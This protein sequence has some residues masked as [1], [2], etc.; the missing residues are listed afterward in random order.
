MSLRPHVPPHPTHDI[1]DHAMVNTVREPLVVLDD[2]LC[3]C[4]ANRAFHGTF[5]LAPEATYGRSIYALDD[6]QWDNASLRRLL[7]DVLP[8]RTRFDDFELDHHSSVGRRILSL[9]A[10]EIL[11]AESGQRRILLAMA[12]VTARR[13]AEMEIGARTRELE[14]FS[15]VASHDLQEP[16]RKIR[17]YAALL[18]AEHAAQLP[19]AGREYVDRMSKAATRMQGL[20]DDMLTLARSS[21]MTPR[22]IPVDLGEVVRDVLVDLDLA[23]RDSEGAVDIGVLPKAVGDPVQ[24]RQ[25]FQNLLSNALKFRRPGVPVRI[26][27]E[28]LPN[29]ADAGLH[30]IEL[31]D[32]GI[33][34]DA[35]HAEQIFEPFQRL[36]A[37]HEYPGNGVGLA[38]CRRIVERHGGEISARGILGEGTTFRLTL[39]AT[40]APTHQEL[41]S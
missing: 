34:V 31:R 5:G 36:H 30:A 4:F 20:I 15:M 35:R 23:L 12:D 27:V 26:V 29:A 14:R 11:L 6:G 22:A 19:E 33:G 3:V 38:L 24:M 40:G 39:P 13:R 2:Q 21:T 18:V 32:N 7:E 9:N 37:R 41:A 17:T 16:L 28:W 25:L 8:A 10:S 1:D